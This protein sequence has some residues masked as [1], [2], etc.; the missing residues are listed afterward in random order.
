MTYNA[1]HELYETYIGLPMAERKLGRID[2]S[3][4]RAVSKAEEL[5]IDKLRRLLRRSRWAGG[6][7]GRALVVLTPYD[8]SATL[9][10]LGA[11]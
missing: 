3:R 10:L 9:G 6:P 2:A 5:L 4:E 7:A 8:A 1:E 11:G